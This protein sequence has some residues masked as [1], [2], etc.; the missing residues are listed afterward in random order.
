G[1]AR[2]QARPDRDEP[3]QPARGEQT[4]PPRLIDPV[5]EGQ[6]GDDEPGAEEPGQ[7]AA[8]E[9][10]RE[11]S[12]GAKRSR[13]G[14]TSRWRAVDGSP[15]AVIPTEEESVHSSRISVRVARG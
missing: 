9:R 2:R 3:E 10:R 5:A 14:E 6:A 8:V 1:N 13:R 11:R 12:H 4:Q 7:T 15:H